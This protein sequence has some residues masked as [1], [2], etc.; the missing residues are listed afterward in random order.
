[1]TSDEKLTILRSLIGDVD[2][3]DD[4]LSIY[5]SV[6][7]QKILDKLY[8][9]S[10]DSREMPAKYDYKQVQIACYLFNKRG[11]EGETA[12][13]ENGINRTYADGDIPASM[14]NDIVPFCEV[15]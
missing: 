1:M 9:F 8:P 4:L 11:A 12:H 5:L 3:D 7:E 14:L 13:S 6:A 2:A 15:L 10:T